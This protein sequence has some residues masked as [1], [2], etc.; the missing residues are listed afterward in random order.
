MST[1]HQHIIVTSDIGVE[2]AFSALGRLL[3]QNVTEYNMKISDLRKPDSL[4]GLLPDGPFT[5]HLLG[6][7][8]SAEYLTSLNADIRQYGGCFSIQRFS[9]LVFEL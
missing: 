5:L 1:D 6:S 2:S 8:W 3:L 9:N 4:N 7:F